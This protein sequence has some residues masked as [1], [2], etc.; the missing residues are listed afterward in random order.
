M[1]EGSP[2]SCAHNLRPMSDDDPR[3]LSWGTVQDEEPVAFDPEYGP[4]VGV[5]LQPSKVPVQCRVLMFLGGAG[6][7]EG[8]PFVA[9]DEVLVAMPSGPR[10]DCAIVGRAP[11][12]IDTYPPTV[13]G[14]DSTK[15]AFS[16]ARGRCARIEEWQGSWTVFSQPSGAFASLS[17]EGNVTLR[18]GSK[19]ALQLSA[20]AMTYQ[21]GDGSH[22]LQVDTQRARFSLRIGDAFLAL[23][24]SGPSAILATGALSLGSSGNPAHEHALS[25]EALAGILTQFLIALGSSVPGPVIGASLAGVAPVVVAT[26]LQLASVTP[27]LP[28]VA[29]GVIAGFATATQKPPGTPALGQLRPGIGCAG[30][31]I[32]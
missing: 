32:G 19:G 4:L 20:D 30:L 24:S 23:A 22:F 14:Q 27:L 12:K 8:H 16:F 5:T 31:M 3:F 13:G 28:P 25:T 26:A 9:G 21:S 2:A 6:E 29:A 18:D 7:G 1:G 17:A 10:G 11:N 15:N